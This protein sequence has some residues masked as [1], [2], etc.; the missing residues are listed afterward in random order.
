MICFSESRFLPGRNRVLPGIRISLFLLAL[1]VMAGHGPAISAPSKPANI[2]RSQLEAAAI[3]AGDYL[4][5]QANKDGSFVYRINMNPEVLLRFNY[6]WLRHAG[7]LYSLADFYDATRRKD[8]VPVI[9]NGAAYMQRRAIDWVEHF[10]G[11]LAVWS[12]P[13]ITGSP[14]PRTAKLGGAG[15]G[16]VALTSLERI[17]PGTVSMDLK[18]GLARFILAMQK[19][20]GSYYSKHTP[21]TGGPS[22]KWT[23][24]YYPGE[25]ALGLTMLYEQDKNSKWLEGARKTLR[26]LSTSRNGKAEVPADHWALIATGRMWPYLSRSDRRMFKRHARQVVEFILNQQ[27]WRDGA[28]ANGGFSRWP[29]TAPAATRLEGLLAAEKL[30]RDE[31]EFH[32]RIHIAMSWGIRFLMKSRVTSGRYLGA[33]PRSPM[34]IRSSE[35]GAIKFNTR[36]TEVRI[37]YVQHALSAFIGY[38][39]FM[40]SRK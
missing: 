35:P 6:N 8:V 31:P 32:N 33:I 23:S 39:R 18:T 16:L 30:F 25:A 21:E 38:I 37:D 22:D 7:S 5:S 9:V 2:D 19:P 11:S 26:F 10:P 3:Q 29:R 13:K 20:D 24:L 34:R 17:K 27:F 15:L 12:D 36:A 1:F 4:I 40:E 28:I 14:T